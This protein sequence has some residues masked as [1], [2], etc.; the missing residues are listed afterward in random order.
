MV[1]AGSSRSPFGLLTANSPLCAELR[2]LF[3]K[4]LDVLIIVHRRGQDINIALLVEPPYNV[5]DF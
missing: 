2:R 4:S 3:T 5:E 1:S